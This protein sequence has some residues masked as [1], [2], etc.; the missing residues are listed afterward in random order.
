MSSAIALTVLN[1][2][3]F[4][5]FVRILGGVF[6]H[7]PWVAQSVADL[8]PFESVDAL[9]QAM[10]GAIEAA[11]PEAQLALICAH[12]E[13]AGKAAI[14]GQL[15]LEST[16]EQGGA[17]LD[18]CTP[19]QF[20]SLTSLNQAFREKFVFPFI[21]AVR[22]YDRAGI[23]EQFRRRLSLTIEAEKAESLQQIYKIGRLR[24]NDLVYE[25]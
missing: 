2:K 17:G 10:V 12:P 8:R 20:S 23:I 25:A 16:A 14:G 19:E 22:G 4:D 9:H 13:L 21:L 6:E 1:A 3:S 11:G 18:N 7:S 5:E 15:T 24:L